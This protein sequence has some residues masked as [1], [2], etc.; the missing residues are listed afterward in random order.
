MRSEYRLAHRFQVSPTIRRALY[1][2]VVEIKSVYVDRCTD[3]RAPEK[4]TAP[5]GAVHPGT[6][7]PG[8]V[9]RVD[10]IYGA[11]GTFCQRSF[12]HTNGT[13]SSDI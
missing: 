8:G 11:G 9:K 10:T 4:A 6:E 3:F 7:A 13:E 2:A 5:G 1:G 12:A